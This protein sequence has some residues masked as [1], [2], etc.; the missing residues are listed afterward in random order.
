MSH[1]HGAVGQA[2]VYE[3]GKAGYIHLLFEA[4][5]TQKLYHIARVEKS[6]T[7]PYNSMRNNQ[8]ERFNQILGTYERYQKSGLKAHVPVYVHVYAPLNNQNQNFAILHYVW[9][10]SKTY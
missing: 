5:R 4:N 7:T 1:L 2:A 3:C 9:V 10:T 6:R 8:V